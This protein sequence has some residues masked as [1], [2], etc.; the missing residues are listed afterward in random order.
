MRPIMCLTALLWGCARPLEAWCERLYEV[1]DAQCPEMQVRDE[2]GGLR[3]PLVGCGATDRWTA[4]R[5]YAGEDYFFSHET[6]ELVAV[7]IWTDTNFEGE[8][9]GRIVSCQ[10]ACAYEE[11]ENLAPCDDDPP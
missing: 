7:R 3:T 2:Q 9:Y 8:W 1:E 4:S 5:G 6:G 10:P 11:D